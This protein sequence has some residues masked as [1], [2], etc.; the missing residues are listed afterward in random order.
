MTKKEIIELANKLF[1]A[2]EGGK[3][4]NDEERRPIFITY[5]SDYQKKLLEEVISKLNK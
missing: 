4:M 3:W 5:S 1:E 2:I